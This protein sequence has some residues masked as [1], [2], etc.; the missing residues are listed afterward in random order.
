LTGHRCADGRIRSP[1]R[2]TPR[3]SHGCEDRVRDLRPDRL[4]HGPASAPPELAAWSRGR[5][6]ALVAGSPHRR[7]QPSG[8]TQRDCRGCAEGEAAGLV[9]SSRHW[10]EPAE[11]TD[12]RFPGAGRTLC[13]LL[14]DHLLCLCAWPPGPAT[15]ITSQAAGVGARPAKS[16]ARPAALS[17][18]GA[19][20]AHGTEE[21]LTDELDVPNRERPSG[22][23]TVEG[24]MINDTSRGGPPGS[25]PGRSRAAGT[26]VPRCGTW[27]VTGLSPELWG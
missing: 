9:R 23:S 17:M 26:W 18:A 8:W 7:R 19:E 3:R 10:E 20:S 6:P 4:R 16:P 13:P 5:A 25:S 27:T 2:E 11:P 1:P 15:R 22:S 21:R 14:R 12:A 24:S